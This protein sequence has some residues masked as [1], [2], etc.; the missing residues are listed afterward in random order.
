MPR[1]PR[2]STPP[3]DRRARG[4]PF[5]RPATAIPANARNPLIPQS[6][7]ICNVQRDALNSG[8]TVTITF[9]GYSGIAS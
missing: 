9:L 4:G 2:R 1:R 7:P 6:A 3:V 5:T 8:G